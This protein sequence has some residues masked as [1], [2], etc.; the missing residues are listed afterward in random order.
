[1]TKENQERIIA[2]CTQLKEQL[3]ER[4]GS[5]KKWR[6]QPIVGMPNATL[7]DDFF[8]VFAIRSVNESAL[9]EFIVKYLT[10]F[11][12]YAKDDQIVL[13]NVAALVDDVNALKDVYEFKQLGFSGDYAQIYKYLRATTVSPAQLDL[14]T[15]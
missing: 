11:D 13:V 6:I 2:Y 10:M 1:M 5:D 14:L 9:M 7:Y 15:G 12:D 3:K 4:Y 8:T